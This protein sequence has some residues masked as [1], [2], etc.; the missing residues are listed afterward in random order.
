MLAQ[1]TRSSAFIMLGFF[2]YI[3]I[4]HSFNTR[5]YQHWPALFVMIPLAMLPLILY[6]AYARNLHCEP[7]FN[8]P[9]YC[10]HILPMLYSSVQLKY[11]DVGFLRFYKISNI[12]SF[13][14][15]APMIILTMTSFYIY[16][17]HDWNRFFQLGFMM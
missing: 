8:E 15:A 2:L 5:S 4:H 12:P 17:K 3:A 13:L 16:A 14:L 1:C 10:Q 7:Q 11:W 9:Q 6:E